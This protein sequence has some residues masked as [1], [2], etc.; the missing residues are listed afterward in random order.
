MGESMITGGAGAG[1]LLQL[2]RDGRPRTR[3]ELTQLTGLARSTVGA[4]V[5][6]LLH[7]GLL[8]PAGEAVSTGGRP[9]ATFAFNPSAGVVL[10]ADLGATHATVAVTDLAATVLA[11]RVESMEITLGPRAVL[12][13]MLQIGAELLAETGRTTVV[14]T[15]IGLPGPVEHSTGR[16]NNPPIMP[17]W[18]G[19]DV[20]GHVA[21][22]M[23]GPVLV[24]NDVNLMALGEHAVVYPDVDHLLFVKIATGIGA[25]I[26]NGGVLHRGAQGVAGDLG[27]VQAM[28]SHEVAC[29]CGNLGCLEA[30]AAGPAIAARVRDAG[31]D[32]ADVGALIDLVRAGDVVAANEVRAAGRRIGEVL[33]SCV[34][35]LNPSVVV[36][37][38]QLANAA[39][40]LLAGVREVV[41]ARSLPLATGSLQIVSARTGG[42]AGVLG[43]ATMVLQHVLS[44][45]EVDAR[46]VG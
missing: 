12:D 33:A 5:D 39:E 44:P 24:D 37:G 25:G 31:G 36:I 40:S 13:R 41:Y 9:P 28:G 23:G 14:G 30:V 45:S 2:M 8:A 15:G 18:D 7:N 26:I 1:V 10:A 22:V 17:G 21:A 20:P 38:G 34:S 29:R 35:L 46:L 27:H 43:A 42:Q 4:R 3:A 16:P 32:A 19:Y 6:L 11:E